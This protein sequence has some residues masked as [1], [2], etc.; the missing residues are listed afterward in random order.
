M[1]KLILFLVTVLVMAACAPKLTEKVE[2]SFPNGQPQ[3][4][5]MLDKSGDC[6]KEIEYYE[7]GQVKME[8]AMKDGKRE[9]EWKAYLPDGR[10]QSIGSFKA[11]KMDG[12]TTVYWENG[13]LR[14]EGFYKAGKHCG[15]WKYYDEQGNFL[16]EVDYGE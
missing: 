9:G 7:T 6:V 16:N 14:W 5:K 3:Y 4:V 2:A 13:N 11:G 12:A 8:G 15:K 1:K 10:P